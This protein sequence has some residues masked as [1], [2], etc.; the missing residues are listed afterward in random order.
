MEVF[1]LYLS[2]I[3]AKQFKVIVTQ[4]P[5]GEGET[6]SSLPFFENEKDWR[7]TLIKT[8]ETAV[9]KPEHFPQVEET[10]WMVTKAILNQDKSTFHPNYLANIGQLLYQTLFPSGSRVK[11]ILQEALRFSEDKNT[12]LHIQL[13]FE[14]DV[15]QRSRLADYPWELLH[16]GQKFLLHRN[17]TISRYIAHETV[18][19]N[20]SSVKLLNVMLVSSSAFDLELGLKPLSKKER[21]AI[22]KGL[23]S[24]SDA[25][26]I[27][28]TELEEATIDSLR[29]CLTERQGKDTPHVLHFDGHGLFGKRCPNPE[30]RAINKGIKA[31]RCRVCN[32]LLLEQPQGYLVFEDEDGEPDYV[33]A[34]ELGTLLRQS[35]LGD[36][37]NQNQ[38]SGVVLVVLSACQSGMAVAGD[39]VFNGTAQNLISHRIPAVVAMQYSISV[40]VA[41]NFAEQFYRSLGQKNSLAVAINQ[42]REA[43]GISSN[44][45]YRPVLYLRWQN[46]QGGQLFASPVAPSST[47]IPENL[48]RISIKKFV[49]RQKELE[50][51]HQKLQ[52]KNQVA[53]CAIAGMGGVGKT[54]LALQYA[55]YHCQQNTYLGGICYLQGRDAEMETQIVAFARTRLGLQVAEVSDLHIQV[56][57]C[58]RNWPEGDV[59]LILDDIKDFKHYKE[60]AE[61][62]S[63]PSRFKVLITTRLQLDKLPLEL[64][65]LDVL[66]EEA[67]LDLLE[68][69]IGK[70]KILQELA[71]AKKLCQRLGYLPLA[72]QLVGH[73][74]E[75]RKLSLGKMLERLEGK[76][77]RHKSLDKDDND[78]TFTLNIKRGVTAA[79]EL[80]WDELTDEAKQLGC[81]LSLFAL[82]P[83]PWLLV[84]SVNT[85]Q[86]AEDLEDARVKLE[87][88]HFLQGYQTYRLHQ[89]I[90]EFFQGKLTQS[91]QVDKLQYLFC[92][93]MVAVAKKVSESPT[94]N[95]IQAIAPDMPHVAEIVKN[96]G[97]LINNAF[98]NDDDF[99]LLF[100][101][102]AGFYT[103]Q[104]L[105]KEAKLCYQDY[106]S[107]AKERFGEDSLEVASS[108]NNLANVHKDLGEY[109]EARIYYQQALNLSINHL[110]ENHLDVATIMNNLALLYSQQN[111]IKKEERDNLNYY[112]Q[113]EER[114]L[115]ARNIFRKA[116]KIRKFY[117]DENHPIVAQSL[118]HLGTLYAGLADYS[119]RYYS[120]TKKAER[121]LQKAIDIRTHTFKEHPDIAESLNNLACLYTKMYRYSEAESLF[122]RA[123]ALNKRL[124]GEKHPDVALGL[125]NLGELYIVESEYS[126]A[127]FLFQESLEI[128]K[129]CLGIDHP[130]VISAFRR[131]EDLRYRFQ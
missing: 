15:V 12:Q 51:L 62:H 35:S 14:A 46:N 27:C 75:K 39:S 52:E 5:V 120:Y 42:G 17:V 77:L 37:S 112:R 78:P 50:I 79:F 96:R 106:L 19:P 41:T 10:D 71:D 57:Y 53:I 115:E 119:W 72:L 16:D 28:L 9:F 1:E 101:G 131:L 125:W 20:L 23:K 30:C 7:T 98:L 67:A 84:E 126:K 34:E 4:S 31:E 127:K 58:L 26:H 85:G 105:Y 43:M 82:A 90:R 66:E 55:H 108:L 122:F 87:D 113:T 63:L 102:I 56:S 114:Y 73:Y 25:G 91:Q 81:L 60:L 100:V 24:A 59:L 2:P 123:L 21:Q 121:L 129:N 97:I 118:N 104:G 124:L 8:L 64:L 70:E 111:S 88:F 13:K 45:W 11:G 103:A 69:R 36:G 109:D 40:A 33:G 61:Q 6:E 74:I 93:A 128:L 116:L 89:L 83:I 65:T 38:S 76:G 107:N 92:H 110:G 68:Q 117:L 49:G 95:D 94:Q 130:L 18:P 99:C 22:C 44:Q 47:Y 54:E 48:P 80:S 86:D 29:A 3:N 32:T